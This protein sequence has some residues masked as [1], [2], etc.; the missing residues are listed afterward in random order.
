MFI[1]MLGRS[2]PAIVAIASFVSPAIANE[3]ALTPRVSTIVD[4]H[5]GYVGGVTTDQLGHVYV[6]DFADTVWRLNPITG[7]ISAYATGRYGAS[8]NTLDAAGELYQSNFY[9]NTV[10]RISRS[11]EVTRII[12]GGVSGPVGI[13]F[14]SEQNLYVCSC[15]DRTI[16]KLSSDGELS[17]FA[18]SEHFSCPNGI[19]IDDRGDL[20]VVSFSDPKIIKVSPE[21]ETSVFA[22]TGGNG[23]GHIIFLRGRFYATSF[24]DNKVYRIS[25]DGTVT[26]F[27]GTGNRRVV[28]GDALQASFSNPNGIAADNSGT[29]LYINDYLGDET[30]TGLD[31]TPFAVR[32]IELPR[33]G[34]QVAHAIK[35]GS[36]ADAERAYRAFKSNPD[37][38]GDETEMETI[39]LAWFYLMKNEYEKAITIFRLTLES[40][41]ESWQAFGGLGTAYQRSGQREAAIEAL[42]RSL[43][44]NPDNPRVEKRLREVRGE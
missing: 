44:I 11:G 27:A 34:R 39:N 40:Y 25:R 22:D 5:T 24:V 35:N 36:L 9:G 33:V 29:Y 15:H 2:L 28:D 16:K 23:V 31:T 17:T 19:T 12:D 6:A 37:N 13:V 42:E 20:Y 38:A 18:T 4:S 10:D 41:P 1:G 14:D 43:V 7:E 26:H 21:G 8:G 30:A 32:Q 3:P